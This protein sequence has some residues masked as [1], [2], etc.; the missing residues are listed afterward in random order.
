MKG[1]DQHNRHK[2]LPMPSKVKAA[3]GSRKDTK[4]RCR[5]F[6]SSVPISRLWVRLSFFPR[7]LNLNFLFIIKKQSCPAQDDGMTAA[8]EHFFY[9]RPVSGGIGTAAHA[10]RSTL[11]SIT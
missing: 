2:L 8:E 7:S 6:C 1:R 11:L 10:L 4:I 9:A 5:D 3:A